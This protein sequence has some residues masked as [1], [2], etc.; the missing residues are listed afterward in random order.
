MILFYVYPLKFLWTLL[1]NQMTGAAV[2]PMIEPHQV[3]ALME[4]FSAGFLA[5]SII[6]LLLFTR[7]LRMRTE[8][9]LNSLEILETRSSIGV[10]VINAG[11]ALVSLAIAFFGGPKYGG[12]AGMIYPILLCPTFTIF[13]SII[14]RR[15]RKLAAA[16]TP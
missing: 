14:G 7:A 3:P 13:Y 9:D 15:K 12:W 11:T 6:F 16:S 1:F 8:L 2:E 4:I 10:N 5:V